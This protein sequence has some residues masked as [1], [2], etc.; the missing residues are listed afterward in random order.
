MP[1]TVDTAGSQ[2]QNRALPSRTGVSA[3]PSHDVP[4]VHLRWP[5][6]AKAQSRIALGI[7]DKGATPFDA[8]P[9]FTWLPYL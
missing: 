5:E 1:R 8:D 9:W 6:P 2:L 4:F 3:R 7:N